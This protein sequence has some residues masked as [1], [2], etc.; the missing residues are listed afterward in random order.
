MEK[1][2]IKNVYNFLIIKHFLIE[3]FHNLPRWF[4]SRLLQIVCRWER[5]KVTYIIRQ[6]N[7]AVYLEHLHKYNFVVGTPG[8]K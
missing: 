2:L 7:S 3:I 4:Q 5:V 8:F 6:D 1:L